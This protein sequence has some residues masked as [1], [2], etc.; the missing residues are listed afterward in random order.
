MTIVY[1]PEVVQGSEEWMALRCGRLT[2]SEMDLIITIPKPE[3]RVKKNGE[4][5]KQREIEPADTEAC[6]IHLYELMAQRITKYVE[7]QYI[8]DEMLRGYDD[9][10]EAKQLYQKHFAPIEDCGF[11]TNDRFGFVIGCSPDALVGKTGGVQCKSRRMK[12]Q[13]QTIC[14]LAMPDEF[15]VQVQTELLVTER[16][17][18]DFLSFCGGMPMVRIRIYP[19]LKVQSAIVEAATVFEEKLAAKL[20][21]YPGN[22]VRLD[23]IAT[24]R[25]IR[26]EMFT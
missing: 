15:L 23:G 18:W 26:Q 16:E 2:A 7:P 17:W 10:I 8:G 22:V 24:E 19:D 6:R 21:D 13:A 12:Y 1:H 5:Y 4:P 14:D 3:T 20:A 25:K 9:E 11:V